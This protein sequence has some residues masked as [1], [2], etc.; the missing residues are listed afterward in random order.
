MNGAHFA[1]S[2]PTFGIRLQQA[3]HQQRPEDQ[4]RDR[5]GA[6]PDQDADRHR[7]DRR[8]REDDALAGQQPPLGGG[9]DGQ[10][11]AADEQVADRPRRRT[12]RPG[13]RHRTGRRPPAVLPSSSAARCGTAWKLVRMVPNRY[14]VVTARAAITII[15]IWLSCAPGC[16]MKIVACCSS[17]PLR[18]PVVSAARPIGQHGGDDHA[19]P[20]RAGGEELDALDWMHRHVSCPPS[21]PAATSVP[22]AGGSVGR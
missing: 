15:T 12:R 13:R 3:L 21:D 17:A 1:R 20:R 14:S 19:P 16:V 11:R 18:K 2:S 5:T 7:E 4:D 8:Q 22:E 6:L 9:V 10:V